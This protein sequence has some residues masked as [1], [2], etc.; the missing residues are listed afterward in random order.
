MRKRPLHHP[1]RDK[2][3]RNPLTLCHM[4]FRCV[5]TSNVPP[6]VIQGA[7]C[8]RG[9]CISIRCITCYIAEVLINQGSR[10]TQ[11][12]RNTEEARDFISLCRHRHLPSPS[13]SAP[14][15]QAP[16][17]HRQ[18]LDVRPPPRQLKSSAKSPAGAI[19]RRLAPLGH[20]ALPLPTPAP[21]R[22]VAHNGQPIL[23]GRYTLSCHRQHQ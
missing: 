7:K 5:G 6:C 17:K 20:G 10:R 16:I 13:H 18:E 1:R 2:R 15:D 21:M 11:N 9:I 22:H 23:S 4:Q 19:S 12:T 3:S 8:D 14:Q